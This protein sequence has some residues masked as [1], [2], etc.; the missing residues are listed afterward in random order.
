[1]FNGYAA[2]EFLVAT[3]RAVSGN[4]P[5]QSGCARMSAHPFPPHVPG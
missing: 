5:E 2:D 4:A 3:G 1:M